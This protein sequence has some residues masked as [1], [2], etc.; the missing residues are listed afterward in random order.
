ME[1]QHWEMRREADNFHR[2]RPIQSQHKH[3]T[4]ACRERTQGWLALS[5]EGSSL[6]AQLLDLPDFPQHLFCSQNAETYIL[7]VTNSDDLIKEGT[8]VLRH[9]TLQL[10]AHQVVIAGK[11]PNHITSKD[12]RLILG[13]GRQKPQFG[14]GGPGILDIVASQC[15]LEGEHTPEELGRKGRS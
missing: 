6:T 3:Q 8:N 15:L 2:F 5:S 9:C 12:G 11:C 13:S 10:R 7:L 14:I 4:K 1:G